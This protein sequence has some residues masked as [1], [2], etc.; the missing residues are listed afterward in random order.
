MIYADII[1]FAVIAAFLFI[2]LRGAFGQEDGTEDRI[3]EKMNRL[4]Q[5]VKQAE[6][7]HNNATARDAEIV[8]ITPLETDDIDDKLQEKIAK[9][10]AIDGSFTLPNFMGGANMAFEMILNAYSDADRDTLKN[11]LST[12]IYTMFDEALTEGENTEKREHITLISINHSVVEKIVLRGNKAKITVRFDSEQIRVL[13]NANGDVVDG[14]A[15][16]IDLLDDEW[17][18]ERDL[19]AANPNWTVI[20]T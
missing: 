15:S 8:D 2:K 6:T 9:I 10:Q 16:N 13:K 12:D 1:F 4:Q 17:T 19:R 11:L 3:R 20:D 18:F 14:T 7:R 5:A